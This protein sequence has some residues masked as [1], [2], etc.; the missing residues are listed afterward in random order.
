VRLHETA[1]AYGVLLAC[2]GVGGIAG[3]LIVPALRARWSI[4]RILLAGTLCYAAVLM[5]LSRTASFPA[6][7]AILTVGGLAGMASVS[8]F[9]IAAQSALPGGVR[10]RGLA[11]FQ[12]VFMLAFAGGAAI[13]GQVA[14]SFGIAAALATA[15]GCLGATVVLGIRYRLAEAQRIDVALSDRPEP[16]VP[17][18]LCP[19]DG[20][21]QLSVEY[22]IS[23]DDEQHFLAA[24]VE[25][26]RMRRRDGALHWG[27]YSDPLVPGRHVETFLTPSWT[28]HQRIQKR[29]TRADR[30]VLDRVSS[31]HC[32]DEPPLTALLGHDFRRHRTH[33]ERMRLLAHLREHVPTR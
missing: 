33:G 20:P 21:V 6:A 4:D 15:G 19:D 29:V 1:A 8:S 31:L 12:L 5:G 11:V 27:L 30:A 7:C 28:E 16:Y 9:N 22:R 18:T 25:L 14:S 3:T 26:G 2:V 24:I 17:V 23:P 10:G 32:G 13:W